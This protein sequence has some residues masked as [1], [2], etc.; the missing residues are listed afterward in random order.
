MRTKCGFST[1]FQIVSILTHII[2][3]MC[4]SDIKDLPPP[5]NVHVTVKAASVL[6]LMSS[7]QP[8]GPPPQTL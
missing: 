7:A 3:I 4:H 6:G 2:I 1:R 8:P 5:S